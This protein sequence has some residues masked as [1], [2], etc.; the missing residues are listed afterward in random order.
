MGGNV[1]SI[2]AGKAKFEPSQRAIIWRLRRFPGRQEYSILADVEL[3]ATVTEKQWVR[4]PINMTFEVPQFTSSGLRVRFLKVQ[5][6]SNY[7]PVKW[8]RYVTRAGAFQHRLGD[9]QT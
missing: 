3:A 1:T 6:K 5:E 8:I 2:S 4:P 7:K 9:K